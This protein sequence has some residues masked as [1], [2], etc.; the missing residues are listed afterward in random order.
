LYGGKIF[1]LLFRNGFNSWVW[2]LCQK[3]MT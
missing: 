2:L 3:F 1:K